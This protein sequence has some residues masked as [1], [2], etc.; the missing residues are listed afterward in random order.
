MDS[1]RH[2][3]AATP[4]DVTRIIG[5]AYIPTAFAHIFLAL[6][7]RLLPWRRDTP[8]EAS[9]PA[10]SSFE[11]SEPAFSPLSFALLLKKLVLHPDTF[12]LDDTRAAFYHLASP[13]GASAPQIGA[14]LSAL[15]LT[16]KDGQPS[17]VAACADVM[18]RH[19]LAVD[20]GS[21]GEGPVCDIVGTGGDG[22]NTFNV[23]TTA[24]IVAAGA[25]CRVYK[26][27]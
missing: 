19:A 14:F 4:R 26:V 2:D 22:Q 18:Q 9:S 24:G 25:G 12:T 8:S 1:Y 21:H 7:T 5:C 27:R 17:V 23:S 20:V 15:R 13:T 3:G 10:P 11:G 6:L 16:G